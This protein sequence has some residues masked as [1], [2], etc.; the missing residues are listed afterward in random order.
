MQIKNDAFITN[1]FI[2]KV[3]NALFKVMTLSYYFPKVWFHISNERVFN[4]ITTKFFQEEKIQI[5]Y[6][7]RK[8]M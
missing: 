4:P 8:C 3:P 7:N 5:P 1:D 6:P 2:C